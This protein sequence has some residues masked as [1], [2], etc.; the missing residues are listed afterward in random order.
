MR[1][2]LVRER[3]QDPQQYHELMVALLEA[4]D[5]RRPMRGLDPP[6]FPAYGVGKFENAA[7][8]IEVAGF[9][10]AEEHSQLLFAHS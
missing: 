7:S 8:R 2:T 6:P 10:W 1:R 4:A 5:Q 3:R 9:L